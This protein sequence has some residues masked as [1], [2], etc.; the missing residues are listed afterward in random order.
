[1]K[2]FTD[3]E[4]QEGQDKAYKEAGDNAYFGYG[5][6]RGVEFAAEHEEAQA[7]Q[8]FPSDHKYLGHHSMHTGMDLRDYFAAKI[9]C[10][11]WSNSEYEQKNGLHYDEV[12]KQAYRAAD[13]MLKARNK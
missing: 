12:A 8:A 7:P 9:L 1:M 13:A 3:E 5:F 10:G 4:I 11:I 2:I 6:R